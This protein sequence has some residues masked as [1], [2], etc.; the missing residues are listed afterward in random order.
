MQSPNDIDEQMVLLRSHPR[1]ADATVESCANQGGDGHLVI[2]PNLALPIGW[3]RPFAKVAFFVPRWFPVARPSCFWTLPNVWL[4][5]GFRLDTGSC[6]QLTYDEED[7]RTQCPGHPG[8]RYWLYGPRM[9]STV[10]DTLLT[11]AHFARQR[12]YSLR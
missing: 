3:N 4:D 8:S 9:W 7:E 6:P 11:Y 2:I 5:T 10:S 1:F 12:F